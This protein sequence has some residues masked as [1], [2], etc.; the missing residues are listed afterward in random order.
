M[1]EKKKHDESLAEA[2]EPRSPSPST[3]RR[4]A[5]PLDKGPDG[6]SEIRDLVSRRAYEFYEG[7]GRADGEDVN[8]WLRAE[9]EVR[10]SL[11]ADQDESDMA[12]RRPAAK[13][14]GGR[15]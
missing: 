1:K 10:A 14:T 3:K 2:P 9:A 8:D 15:Q 13:R 6:Q 4:Q 11:G 12:K 7:R 5:F